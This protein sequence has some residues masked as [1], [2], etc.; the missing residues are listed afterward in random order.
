MNFLRNVQD[1]LRVKVTEFNVDETSIQ[2]R[3]AARFRKLAIDNLDT[4]SGVV[5]KSFRGEYVNL[6]SGDFS[7]FL[8][9]QSKPGV[10]GTYLEATSLGEA[11][12]CH[13]IVTPVKE[14]IYQ[15]PICLY[16]ASDEKAP[17][18]NLYNS[19]N[20]HWYVN[21]KTM[22][23]GNCLYN[24]FAQA[25]QTVINPKLSRAIDHAAAPMEQTLA[26]TTFFNTEQ[27]NHS[28][29]EE[30]ITI[31][32]QQTILESIQNHPTPQE[33]ESDCL[34][35][36]TRISG[37]PKSEQAQIANDYLLALKLAREDMG[38]QRS[39]LFTQATDKKSIYEGT[40]DTASRL[41]H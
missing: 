33:L 30:L 32:Y 6:N 12:G 21:E 25:I 27:K 1:K 31:K 11:L 37:L 29:K 18:V 13:V 9:K 23:D 35:E 14:G 5:A 39:N 22:K 38:Y 17:T 10:W 2:T 4:G 8:A 24:A 26:H 19:N 7:A 28:M 41:S 40:L 20:T 36:Q 34:K 3:L 15:A 16:R